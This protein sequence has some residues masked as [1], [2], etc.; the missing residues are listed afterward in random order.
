MAVDRIDKRLEEIERRLGHIDEVVQADQPRRVGVQWG[1]GG[2]AP[3]AVDSDRKQTFELSYRA[4]SR[5][6]LRQGWA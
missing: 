4:Q 5:G 1:P 3:S 2:A 6:I